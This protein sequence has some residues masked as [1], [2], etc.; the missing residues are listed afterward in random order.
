MVIAKQVRVSP[1]IDRLVTRL[2]AKLKKT[3]PLI[4]DRQDVI[5]L[6]ITE[7]AEREL[8]R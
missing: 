6:A 5:S 8:L 7:L 1:V 3:N 2:V 4:K